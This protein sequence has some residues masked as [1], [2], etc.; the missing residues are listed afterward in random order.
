[1][2]F[3]HQSP[4]PPW[5]MHAQAAAVRSSSAPSLRVP[6]TGRHERLHQFRGELLLPLRKI[7]SIAMSPSSS[8]SVH[9]RTPGLLL[10]RRR[11]APLLRRPWNR[12]AVQRACLSLLASLLTSA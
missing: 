1:V 7:P 12:E 3:L 4:T 6:R 5:P 2:V 11:R 10:W 8:S 9:R